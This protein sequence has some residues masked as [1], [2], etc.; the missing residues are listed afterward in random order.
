MRLY[1]PGIERVHG[2]RAIGTGGQRNRAGR[3]AVGDGDVEHQERGDV[4]CRHFDDEARHRRCGHIGAYQ[5]RD[6]IE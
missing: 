1:A 3:N 4:G 5:Q 2:D 6:P